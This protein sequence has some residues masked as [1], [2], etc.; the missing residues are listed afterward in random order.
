MKQ[1][2]SIFIMTTLIVCITSV[3]SAETNLFD[4]VP[5]GHWAY[6]AVNQL[7]KD[8]IIKG[9]GNG[10]YLGNRNITRYEMAQMIARAYAKKVRIPYSAVNPFYDIPKNHWAK[11]AVV[12]LADAGIVEGYGDNTFLG[13]RNI[14]RFEMA[15]MIARLVKKTESNLKLKKKNEYFFNDVPLEHWAYNSVKFLSEHSIVEG[16]G[17]GTYLGYR[18]ITRYEMAQMIAK[19]MATFSY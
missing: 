8:G 7:D 13:S 12:L 2:L 3:V 16:Y 14:N 4:D 5:Y 10:N 17:D 15:Q 6:D 18:H 9:Y 1:K 19:V 11:K